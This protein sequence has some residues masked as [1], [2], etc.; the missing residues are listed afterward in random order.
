MADC[1]DP[2]PYRRLF[3]EEEAE[4]RLR[5]YRK[6]GLDRMAARLFD[7]LVD[8]GVVGRTLLEVGGGVGDLQ[9]ELLKAGA[10]SAVNVELSDGYETVASRLLDEEG[11][12]GKVERRLGDFVDEADHVATADIVVLNRVIC[13][14]PWVDR[15]M[16]A[17][18]AKTGS[19][20]ALVFPRDHWLGHVF[21]SVDNAVNRL[22]GGGF[23]AYLHPTEEVETRADAADLAMVW[24]DRGLIWQGM[25]FGRG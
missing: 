21:I 1:C 9:V 11:L 22:R 2:M 14:Y 19:S 4:R 12:T 23:R 5:K 6:N 15:M 18:T 17:A 20:L 25:V 3:N 13:C 7:A 8:R 10:A 16:A 24:A